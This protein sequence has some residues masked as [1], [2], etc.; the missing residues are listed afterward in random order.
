MK[1]TYDQ[2]RHLSELDEGSKV[3]VKN[4]K[5]VVLKPTRKKWQSH[6]ETKSTCS[7]GLLKPCH[8]SM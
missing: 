7:L 5:G 1:L 4:K 2:M 6:M 8:A 3:V